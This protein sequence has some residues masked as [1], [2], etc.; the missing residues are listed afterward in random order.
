MEN[1]HGVNFYCSSIHS[2]SEDINKTHSLNRKDGF[3]CAFSLEN[4]LYEGVAMENG[5]NDRI[6]YGTGTKTGTKN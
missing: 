5:K 4:P 1:I 6:F 3:V 2:I